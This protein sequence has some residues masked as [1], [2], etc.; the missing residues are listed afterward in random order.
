MLK[1][2]R[3][4]YLHYLAN[5][6]ENEML[7]KAFMSQWK[8]PVKDDWTE[9]VK[10]NL[11]ELGIDLSLE[12][13]KK[14]SQY[15]FKRMVKVKTHECTLKYLLELKGKHTKMENLGLK[16]HTQVFKYLICNIFRPSKH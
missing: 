4:N 2:R 8:Y 9:E 3:V 7:Y 13:I 10:L 11:K 5:Q 15:S 1:A 6:N 12:E 16:G 14:T